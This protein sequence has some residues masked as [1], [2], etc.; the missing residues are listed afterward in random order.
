[1]QENQPQEAL[2]SKRRKKYLRL[3]GIVIL[4]LFALQ[5]AFYFGSDLLLRNFLKEKVNA[6]SDNKYEIDFEEFHILFLQRGITFKGLKLNPVEDEFQDLENTPYFRLSIPEIDITGLNYR[7]FRKEFVIGTIELVNPEVDFKLAQKD[8]T[9]VSKPSVSPILILQEEIKKSFLGSQVKEIRIKTLK[10]DD[11]DL[12]MKNFISQKAIKAENTRLLL[13][14]IQLLQ[15]RKP[16]TP[17]NAKGFSFGFDNFEVLLADSI[18]TIQAQSVNVSSLDQFI[19]AKQVKITPDF[20]KP[21]N[22]YFQLD[23][24]DLLLKDA[25]INRVFYTSEVAVGQLKIENPEF[26]LYTKESLKKERGSEPFDLYALV[27]GIL[28][29]IQIQDLEIVEGKFG[30]RLADSRDTY[31]IKTDRIDFKMEDFYVGPDESKKRDQFFYADNASVEVH[32]VEFAL[33]D[34][35]HRIKGDFVRLSSFDD[36]IEIDGFKFYPKEGLEL[37]GKKA[38]LDIR[39]AGLVIS[40]ANLKK[41]YNLGVIDLEEVILDEPE[42][43][44]KNIQGGEKKESKVGLA[45]IYSEYLNGIYVERFEIHDGS[46]TLDNKVRIRQDSLS[47]G[48]INLVLENFE[49]DDETEVG[50]TKETFFAENLHLELEDY[51][52]KL[53]DNLHIFKADK[54][55][56]DTK[57]QLIEIDG[58]AIRPL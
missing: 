1:M 27:E 58:F 12:L 43:L 34:S 21:S 29:S 9:Q 52:L 41:V 37:D 32:M 38:H 56:L 17:F 19:E 49:L 35:I 8:T 20:G 13:E 15:E 7:F 2:P 53:A 22:T 57:D 36:K 25:D 18:H 26:N 23:L 50:D 39:V 51:A 24:E 4:V 47:F 3:T 31:M 5:V 45:E 55:L 14:D 11:A 6:S 48:K 16:A 10:I 30:K 40:D 42:I 44:L 46:L 54:I 33:N 28:N